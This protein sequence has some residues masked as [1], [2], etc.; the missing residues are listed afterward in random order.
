MVI[1]GLLSDYDALRAIVTM[2]K[3]IS[4]KQKNHFLKPA[5]DMI[6]ETGFLSPKVLLLTSL[7]SVPKGS[8][9]DVSDADLNFRTNLSYWNITSHTTRNVHY[10]N[11]IPLCSNNID[12]YR[13]AFF[14]LYGQSSL[15]KSSESMRDLERAI[16][17]RYPAALVT[18]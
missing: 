6:T 3:G 2:H 15:E 11:G 7:N 16:A 5:G 10:I 4:E 1:E 9:L 14:F 18:H 12:T 13:L 17:R 8:L